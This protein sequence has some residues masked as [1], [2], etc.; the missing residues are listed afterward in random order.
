[1][2]TTSKYV[3]SLILSILFIAMLSMS[4]TA[5][6]TGTV[7][8]V[9]TDVAGEALIGANVVLEGTTL[10][11]ATDIDGSYIVLN[12]PAG[13]YT[14]TVSYVSYKSASASATV[15]A[16]GSADVNFTLESDL[17]DLTAVVT[18]GVV[19][20]GSKLESSV[21]IS[22]LN[23]EEAQKL[24]PR[25]TAEIFRTIP[26]VRS[27]ASGGDGNTN[28]TVRG[29]PISAGGSKYLQ[30]QEDGL[31]V[32][33]FGDIAF[34]TADIFLRADNTLARIEAIRGGSASTL[35]S[36]SPAGIINFISKTGAVEGGSVSTT[37]GLDYNSFRT[38]FNYGSPLS[39]S[40]SFHIGGFL[41]QGEGPRTAGYTGNLG[42]QF[43]MNLTQLFD[44]GYGRVYFKYLNDR[45]AAYM[46]MPLKVEGTNSS[47]DW[48][49][50]DGFDA[51]SGT[52]HSPFILQNLG[53]G[54]NG[55]LRRADVADGMHPLSSAVGLEFSRELGDGW[56]FE[57]RGRLAFN[58][59]RFVSPFPAQVGTAQEIAE[60]IGGTGASLQYADGSAFGNGYEG[61]GL[62]LRI[63]MFDTE[64]NKFDNFVNDFRV[65]KELGNANV[66]VGYYLSNQSISMSWLWNSYLTE[67]N[68]ED[69]RLLDVYDVDGNKLSQNGLYAYGVPFWG[70]CCQR[71]YDA[72]YRTAAPYF[73]ADLEVNEALN[74]DASVRLDKGYVS[75]HF[76]G[77]V[78][79]QFD[80]NND[81]VISPNEE[82]V[83]A[84]DNANITPVDYEYDYVS[85]SA[86]G[87]YQLN[88]RQAVFARFSRGG[89]AKADRLL[90]AGLPYSGGTELNAKDVIDQAELGY[91]HLFSNGGLFVTGFM[92]NTT[93]EGGFEATTQEI[94]END[95]EA[96]GVEVEAAF[97]FGQVDIRGG[98][99]FTK[100]EITSGDNMG[101]TPR[102]QPDLMFNLIP[103]LNFGQHSVGL[104]AIGQTKAYAQDSNEL[105]MPAYTYIN[106]FLN[107]QITNQFFALVSGNNLLDTIGITESEEGSIVDNQVN[108]VRARPIPGRSATLTLG[109]NF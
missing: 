20:K 71:N 25:T 86:G 90:F 3:S 88:D 99:T 13:E 103:T 81:G 75:G 87:N 96:L 1:M 67:V 60:D 31:P 104:S 83:S 84:I 53:L 108:Y 73:S 64:L 36:N 63:H 38:D 52:M 56:N 24:A 27:E 32:F 50:I 85:F 72:D 78:Q 26:G 92:A 44:G 12:V 23:I 57:S 37:T 42:G 39:N 65:S 62:A 30:L 51:A 102:R 9:V 46:P 14:V 15:T 89:S 40:I 79:T 54:P 105:V 95:Y 5:Q 69:A 82:S 101:N 4:L 80:V 41:R 8:G 97:R 34:A 6:N 7:R 106:A 49:S 109:Y 61:N 58:S 91:K 100:A 47:P 76:A 45:A 74:I 10:G 66:A 70:N 29:V 33:Q 35:A 21:S 59:G 43:K 11:S 107:Y 55:E 48:D 68:G 28:I 2:S 16:G 22:T 19:N 94:I 98:L 17:L 93:E 18:T 77:T